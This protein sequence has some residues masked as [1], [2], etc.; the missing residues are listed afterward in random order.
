MPLFTGGQLIRLL[1]ICMI[2]SISFYMIQ[3]MLRISGYNG[4]TGLLLA[5]FPTI[6]LLYFPLK[7]REMNDANKSWDELGETILGKWLHKFFLFCFLVTV[8]MLSIV[9]V[10]LYADIFT[11]NYLYNTPFEVIVI[12]FYF[13]GAWSIRNGLKSLVYMTDGVFILVLFSLIIFTPLVLQRVDY[14]MFIA[15]FTHLKAN[16]I[17]QSIYFANSWLTELT[18]VILILHRFENQHKHL[19][20]V[21]IAT[22]VIIVIGLI[23]WLLNILQFGPY[24]GGHIRY[25]MLDLARQINI[26]EFLENLDPLLVSIWTGTLMI[27][28]VFLL[29][30][31]FKLL[32]HLFDITKKNI[33]YSLFLYTAFLT[34]I[35]LFLGRFPFDINQIMTPYFGFFMLYIRLIPTFYYIVYKFR[36][37]NQPVK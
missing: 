31:S 10:V 15:L 27:K 35:T 17:F 3:P 26:G 9:E 34:A 33:Q 4:G 19:R 20:Y 12:V 2:S 5:V 16:P 22:I 23:S 37:G 24:L 8:S 18:F 32:I 7:I 28:N 36:F 14:D 6:L 21:L 13:I 29:Y 1:T 11:N 25:P 30:L